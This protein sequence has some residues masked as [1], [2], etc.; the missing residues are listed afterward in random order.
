M[1]AMK[2]AEDPGLSPAEL[3]AQRYA[4]NSGEPI[5]AAIPPEFAAEL[6]RQVA[7]AAPQLAIEIG[8]A[9]GL[10]SL[11]ILA[12]LPANAQLISI[13]PFQATQWGDAGRMLVAQSNRAAS[14][15]VIEDF[16]YLA[17]PQ[18]LNEGRKA[19]FVYIDGMHTFDYVALDA[20]F[21]DKLLEVGGVIGFNDCG[22][23]SIHKYLKFFRS[24]RHY[25]ELPSQLVPDY[26]GAN[27]MI[28][29][30]RRIEGRSNQ[31]RYFRKLDGW[32]P[33]HN[34]FSRF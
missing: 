4:A 27:P 20:F 17:L 24:H 18:L 13:D 3:L 23:R 11:A 19:Q 28:S 30:V 22:F 15:Q 7:A 25:E 9:N 16:D 8:M 32:E 33:E 1:A 5:H 34:F 6:T 10:S 14:H 26:R 21:A 12:G 2:S 29:L 31:D